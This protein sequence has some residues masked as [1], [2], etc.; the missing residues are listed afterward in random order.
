MVYHVEVLEY[1]LLEIRP[2]ELNG[3]FF[4]LGCKEQAKRSTV[5]KRCG[6]SAK[7]CDEF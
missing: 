2:K 5:L 3:P 6:M 7:G 4:S 1:H